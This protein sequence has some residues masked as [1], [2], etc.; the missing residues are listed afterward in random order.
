MN[1]S[2]ILNGKHCSMHNDIF[3]LKVLQ[4]DEYSIHSMI[5]YHKKDNPCY[6]CKT[7]CKLEHKSFV[8]SLLA[9]VE[10]YEPLS[11]QSH[12]LH[13]QKRDN[14]DL[15]NYFLFKCHRSDNSHRL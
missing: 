12:P 2:K 1:I 11:K 3:D 7:Y 8:H 15:T 14:S 10:F 4:R 6:D 5:N 13:S 9:L